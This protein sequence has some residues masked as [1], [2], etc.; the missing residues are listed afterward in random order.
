MPAGHAA[1]KGTQSGRR[2]AQH[3]A[4]VR[5]E[6]ED[7]LP[8]RRQAE[9]EVD[10]LGREFTMQG[11]TECLRGPLKP[12]DDLKSLGHLAGEARCVALAQASVTGGAQALVLARDLA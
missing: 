7:P 3:L 10:A 1:E 5:V 2:V 11:I 12:F 9:L 8:D 6:R 4:G